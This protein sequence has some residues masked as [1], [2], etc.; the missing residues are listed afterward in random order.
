M[1]DDNSTNRSILERSLGRWGMRVGTAGSSDE[2]FAALQ[3]AH[4]RGDP[5]CL[6]V[7]DMH[8][9]AAGGVA[10]MEQLRENKELNAPTIG[11]VTS[12]G[13]LGGVA[14]CRELSVAA[15]LLK[16][17]RESEL[18]EAALRIVI[19]SQGPAASPASAGP[20]GALIQTMS[21]ALNILV[22]DDTRINQ[23]VASRLL[24]KRGHTVTSAA[25]GQEVLTL[26]EAH[27]FDLILMDVQMPVMSG[28]DATIEIRRRELKT[29]HHV[30]IYAVTANAMKGDRE[31]YLSSGMDGYLE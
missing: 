18:H 29:G 22:A 25:N 19:G 8:M 10:L 2:A 16:P 9:P 28:V 30:L 7:A 23:K 31:R 4:Q 11:M 15:C 14:R 3:T 17:I 27:T 1:V 24:E 20:E 21:S 5:Y 13:H 6:I 26:L 12:A